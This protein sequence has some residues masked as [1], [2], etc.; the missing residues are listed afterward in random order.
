[1]P[2]GGE[3]VIMGEDTLDNEDLAT[4]IERGERRKTRLFAVIAGVLLAASF[5]FCL[6]VGRYTT[7]VAETFAAF[8]YGVVDTLIDVLELP[9]LIPG[10]A[11]EIPNPVPIIW[12]TTSYLVLWTI[13][14]PRMLGVVFVG[15]GLA[16][17][18]ASY[19]GV[20]RNPLVSESIL[21]VT[22]GAAF[23]AGLGFFFYG[24]QYLVMALAFVGAMLAVAA[25]YFS[26]RAFNGN[27][28]L[29]LVLAG[30]V[31]GSLFSA[32]LTVL[33]YLIGSEDARLGDIVF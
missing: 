13:R 1:M 6:V 17:A 19:Q 26:S 11:Y 29:L 16:M 28:T 8:A 14:L 31:V 10:V 2:R 22:A 9:T 15:G 18:G 3:R 32:G 33:Q 21:G 7:G 4:S 5:L 12:D 25:T 24:G 30:T 23:G 27:P 20:F